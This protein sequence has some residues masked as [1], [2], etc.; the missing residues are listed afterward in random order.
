MRLKQRERKKER[1][2]DGRE[3]KNLLFVTDTDRK[4]KTDRQKIKPERNI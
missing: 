1:K 4:R 2:K 3:S